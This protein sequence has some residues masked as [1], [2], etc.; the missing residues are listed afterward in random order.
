MADKIAEREALL[1]QKRAQSAPLTEEEKL[2]E[3]L[4]VQKLEE[5]ANLQLTRDMCG[6]A[7]YNVL[8]SCINLNYLI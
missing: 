2:E 3:K 5:R 1:E 4:R 7:H 6:K 8:I